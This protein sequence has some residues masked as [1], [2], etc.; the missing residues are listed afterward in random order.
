MLFNMIKKHPLRVASVVVTVLSC[1]TIIAFVLTRPTS[2]NQSS[3]AHAQQPPIEPG[4]ID[5]LVQNATANGQSL[6]S[7]PIDVQHE[8]VQG[9]DEAK[10]NYSIVVAQAVSKESFVTSAYDIQ[11]WWKFTVNET[12]LATTPHICVSGDCSLPGT[13]PAANSNELWLAKAGGAIARNGVTVDFQWM[14]F[15]DFNIGQKYLLFIDFNQSTRVAVPAIGPVGAFMVDSNGTMAAVLNEDTNL[16]S[17]ISSRFGN[18]LTQLRNAI[19]PPTQPTGCDPA[20][21]QACSAKGGG[22]YWEADSCSCQFDPCMA[23]PWL[24]D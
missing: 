12:V 10:A 22:Y 7:I 6:V 19:N 9:F 8:D 23:K 18:S 24:C 20:Q 15:P 21:A 2:L 13:L 16:K 11:T 1:L 17:D 5:D 3:A 4:S 14:D